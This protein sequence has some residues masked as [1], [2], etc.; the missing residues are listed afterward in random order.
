MK[1]KLEAKS[2]GSV[3]KQYHDSEGEIF[4]MAE[5]DRAKRRLGHRSHHGLGRRRVPFIENREEIQEH[6]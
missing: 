3:I 6:T 1:N 2:N 4:L 5:L